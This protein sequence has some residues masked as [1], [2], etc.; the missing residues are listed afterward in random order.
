MTLKKKYATERRRTKTLTL[1]TAHGKTTVGLAR[2]RGIFVQKARATVD[3]SGGT[4]CGPACKWHAL[5][6]ERAR[7]NMSVTTLLGRRRH[8]PHLRARFKY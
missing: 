7:E 2:D 1:S 4:C 5:T 6:T 3:R 8:V